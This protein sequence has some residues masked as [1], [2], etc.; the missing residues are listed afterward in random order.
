MTADGPAVGLKS[1]TVERYPSSMSL[2]QN[3]QT[4]LIPQLQRE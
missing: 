2:S 4:S 3:E 1:S